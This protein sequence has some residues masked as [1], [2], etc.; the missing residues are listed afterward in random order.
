MVAIYTE[1]LIDSPSGARP[2][3]PR[4]R[5]DREEISPPPEGYLRLGNRGGLNPKHRLHGCMANGYMA[6]GAGCMA[7]G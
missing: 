1:V 7:H 4:G 5:V 6:H 2:P 3:P